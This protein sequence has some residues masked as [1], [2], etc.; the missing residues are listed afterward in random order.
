MKAGKKVYA[1]LAPATEGQ[2]GKDITMESWRQ[3]VKKAGF[4]DLIEAGLGGDMTTCSEAEE[5]LEAYR[6]GERKQLHAVQ[7]S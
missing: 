4:E 2:F 1:I 3:A 5:W 7:D 6:N